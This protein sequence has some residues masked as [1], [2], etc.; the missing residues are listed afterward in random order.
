MAL[1]AGACFDPTRPCSTNADCVNGGRVTPGRRRASRGRIRTTRPRRRSPSSW[2]RRALVRTRQSCPS[3]D[4][5][6]P[7]GGVDAFRRDESLTVTVTS[8]DQDVDAGSVKLRVFGVASGPLTPV[9]AVLASV[10]PGRTRARRV[11]SVDRPRCRSRRSRSMLSAAVVALEASGSDLS[12]N[13]GSA[14]AG[15]NV[16]R[17]KWRY[18]AGAPIY[19]TPAIADDGTIVFGTSD[20]GSGS[21]Y[22][23]TPAGAEKWAPVALGP[24]RASPAIGAE[25]GASRLRP[26]LLLSPQREALRVDSN[27]TT[28]VSAC[29]ARVHRLLRA[30]FLGCASPGRRRDDG[31]LEGAL[32]LAVEQGSYI[33]GPGRKPDD[34][35]VLHRHGCDQ[36]QQ[37]SGPI[38]RLPARAYLGD[39]RRRSFEPST[40]IPAIG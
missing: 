2:C 5:G 24:I 20:G 3:Y 19:T 37:R 38:R 6:S 15:V 29:P 32:A 18:S 9:D 7:D 22:A 23:L 35:L 10:C 27:R 13:V 12:N 14:D 28:P 25:T 17:W 1:L 11:R 33:S 31:P 30:P 26:R 16:T 4:P 39:G 8:T 34:R 40:S 36:F 21:L